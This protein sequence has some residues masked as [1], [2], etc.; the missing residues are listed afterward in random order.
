MTTTI[1]FKPLEFKYENATMAKRCGF[2]FRVNHL[3]GQE[4]WQATVILKGVTDAS[5]PLTLEAAYAWCNQWVLTFMQQ[6]GGLD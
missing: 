1:Y 5:G 4:K 6:M 2:M 3:C